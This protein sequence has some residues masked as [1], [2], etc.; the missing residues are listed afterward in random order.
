MASSGGYAVDGEAALDV[1]KETEVLAR[2]LDR[3][4]VWA[5]D[6]LV[7]SSVRKVTEVHAPMKPAG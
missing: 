6:E 2:L 1:V 3:D 5:R 7:A 4:N